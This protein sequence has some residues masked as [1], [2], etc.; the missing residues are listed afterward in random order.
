M[1]TG[2]LTLLLGICL[3]LGYTPSAQAYV[4]PGS[5]GTVFQ[6]GYLIFMSAFMALVLMPKKIASWFKALKARVT[7]QPSKAGEK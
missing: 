5:V 1:S 2:S 6:A 7:G 4:D 3:L